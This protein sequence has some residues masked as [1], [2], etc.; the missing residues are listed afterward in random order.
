M[1]IIFGEDPIDAALTDI[2]YKLHEGLPIDDSVE[3]ELVD[4]KEEAGRRDKSGAILPGQTENE[5]A[6]GALTAAAACMANTHR[7]GA[8]LVGVS[9]TGD[10]IGTELDAEWLRQRIWELTNKALTVDIRESEVRGS[11]LLRIRVP[12]ALEPVRYRGRIQWRVGP[13]CVEV[14]A[15]E[16]HARRMAV[17]QYDWSEDESGIAADQASPVALAIARGFL[18]DSA[19]EHANDL[20]SATDADLLRRLNVVSPSGML[21]NAGVLAFVGRGEP[22]L[23]FI[24]RPAPGEDSQLRIRKPGRSL[25]EE[26]T[27]VFQA[28]EASVPVAHVPQGLIIGQAREIPLGAARE[29]IVNGVAHREWG[30]KDPTTIEYVGHQLRVTSP[31]GFV[32]GVTPENILT[33]PSSS[34]NRS[35]AELFASLRIAEREGVGVD[36]MFRD[37]VRL[38]HPA[39]EISEVVGPYVRATLTGGPADQAWLAW[40]RQ[41]QPQDAR[42]IDLNSLLVLRGALDIGWVDEDSIAALIQDSSATARVTVQ[43]MFT[44]GSTIPPL[45]QVA[46]TP[47][48]AGPA[49]RLSHSAEDQLRSLDLEFGRVRDWPSRLTVARS[50]VSHRGRI[51]STELGSLTRAAP[52]NVGSTLKQLEN[53]G[54]VSASWPSR[55]GK[56]FHYVRT[57][58]RRSV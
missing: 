39:P 49:W 21:T 6:A 45:M 40:L 26:L 24:R 22:A 55:R 57:Q 50:Y 18:R 56:G 28:L 37:M 33:H 44:S 58:A 43:R 23:D 52:T 31:G 14:G 8:L 30:S 3:S 54:F 29:A 1:S 15:S 19:E 20:A 41:L 27:E 36:R 9:N 13:R 4:L 12:Q 32:E 7:G 46:G 42:A 2:L 17:M 25:L 53:E 48:E 10:L 35:L 47:E 51:S 34:R 38:G 5:A 11:R 16:W